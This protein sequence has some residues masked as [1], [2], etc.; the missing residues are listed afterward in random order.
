MRRARRHVDRLVLSVCTYVWAVSDIIYHRG[1]GLVECQS[2]G[3][4]PLRR[5]PQTTMTVC[6]SY[7][8]VPRHNLPDDISITRPQHVQA[9]HL[10]LSWAPHTGEYHSLM[11]NNKLPPELERYLLLCQRTYERMER[12][13]SWPWK[14]STYRERLV[15]FEHPKKNV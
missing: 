9:S 12:E 13:N 1:L 15:Q 4:T 6:H 2:G 7:P 10:R 11:S 5:Q 8:Y 3:V 14:D